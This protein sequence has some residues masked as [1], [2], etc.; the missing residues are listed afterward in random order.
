LVESPDAILRR[1]RLRARLRALHR[2]EPLNLRDLRAAAAEAGQEPRWLA[3]RL[4]RGRPFFRLQDVVEKNLDGRFQPVPLEDAVARL[5]DMVQCHA[6]A[7]A[8][9]AG[10]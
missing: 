3:A 2:A 6:A 10:G 8:T 4:A 7:R 1:L 5:R 9:W